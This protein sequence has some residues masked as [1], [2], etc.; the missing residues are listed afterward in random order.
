MTCLWS[1]F[2]YR[3]SLPLIL[4]A[5]TSCV[6]AVGCARRETVVQPGNREQILHRGSI[7]DVSELDP[8]LITGADE[9]DVVIALFEGLVTEDPQDL[10]PV[11]GVA[12]SWDV[13]PDGLTYTFHLRANAKWSNGDSVTASDFVHSYQRLLTPSLAANYAYLLYIIRNAEAFNKG[14]LTDFSQVG[15]ESSDPRTFRITLQHPCT[16]FLSLLNHW[17]WLPVPISTIQKYGPIAQRGN[18]WTRPG[19]IVSNGAFVLK[20]WRHNQVVIVEKNSN[21]WD[22]RHVRLKAIRF[23]AIESLDTEERSF[24]AGQ[25]HLTDAIPVSK[26]DNYRQQ[27]PTVLRIDPYLGVYFYRFNVNR[28]FLNDSK[29]RRALALA[30]DRERIVTDIF[31]GAEYPSHAFTPPHTRG[32]TPTSTIPTDFAEPRKLLPYA[33]YPSGKRLPPL[34]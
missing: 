25:I 17:A 8:Q 11:P 6:W 27:Q 29:V 2:R 7:V 24:R 31:R 5:I 1:L 22:A 13:S 19:Q 9:A 20:E 18:P 33:V 26:I 10:H 15:L 23:H 4:V 14:Q 30:V 3:L 12:E 34:Y 32:Y 28:P 21:Y 16:Y